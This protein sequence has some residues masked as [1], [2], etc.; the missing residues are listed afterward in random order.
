[1]NFNSANEILDFAIKKEE[2]A[3]DFYMG[4]AEKV[5]TPG[6]KQVFKD[7]ALQEKGHKEKLL[8]VKAGQIGLPSDTKV[9]DLKIGDHLEDIGEVGPNID[10]QTALIIAMKSEKN[11][12]R[13]YSDLVAAVTEPNL[14][15]VLIGLANEEAIHKLRFEIEY[16]DHFLTEN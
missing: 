10:Y 12:F 11:A 14:K 4:L 2:E 13:L 5:K 16:D 15:A 9:K 8:Q 1:M 7:F 3:H 6:M